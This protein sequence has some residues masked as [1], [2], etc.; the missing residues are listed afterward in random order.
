MLKLQAVLQILVGNVD[1]AFAIVR[2]PGHHAMEDN[3]IMK[4]EEEPQ[5]P[6]ALG[7]CYYNNV[8]VAALAALSAGD[9]APTLEANGAPMYLRV[10]CACVISSLKPS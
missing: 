7:F 5:C 4:V 6:R 3:A 1:F 10:L 2:P 8:T 9:E